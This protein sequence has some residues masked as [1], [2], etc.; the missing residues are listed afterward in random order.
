MQN[1][2]QTMGEIMNPQ[3]AKAE[4]LTSY[5]QKAQDAHRWTSFSPEKRGEQLIKDY[6]QQLSEDITELQKEGISE[7]VI[8]HYIERY[9]SLFSKW[10][11]AKSGCASTMITGGSNFPVER[12]RKAHRSEENHYSLWQEWRI[13]A[14]KAIVRKPKPEK[15]FVSEI[16]RYKAELASCQKN[17]ELMKEGNKRIKAAKKDGKD[18]SGE[19]MELLNINQFNA[20][21]AMKFGFGLQNNNANIKRLEERIKTLEAKETRSNLIGTN[22]TDFEGGVV[23]Y[24]HEADRIQIKHNEKPASDVIW[25]LKR[26]G[27]K[28]SPSFGAWQRNLNSNGIWAAERLLN[29]KLPSINT[30]L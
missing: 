15:T 25:N 16:D 26:N 23:T 24:N 12:Q 22:E 9:K 20:E 3:T 28:W 21:W 29:I 30:G 13:R 14:K 17:H 7:E 27:F 2:F 10:L 19:L 1:I 5:A 8:N 6:N 4:L 18:I 11:N